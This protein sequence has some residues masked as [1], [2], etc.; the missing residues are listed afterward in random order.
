[1]TLSHILSLTLLFFHHIYFIYLL[2]PFMLFK[3]LSLPAYLFSDS[4]ELLFD[5][6]TPSVIVVQTIHL[7][8]SATGVLALLQI[9]CT[10]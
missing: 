9:E 10:P 6:S 8:V 7:T 4:N 3:A 2:L 5:I 1:M